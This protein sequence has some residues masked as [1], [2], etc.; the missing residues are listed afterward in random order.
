VTKIANIHLLVLLWS[1]VLPVQAASDLTELFEMTLLE[2]SNVSVTAEKR[3]S[4]L[5][6]VPISITIFSSEQLYDSN[7]RDIQE[8]SPYTPNMVFNRIGGQAQIYIRGVGSD[9]LGVGSD[10]ST[11]VHLDGIYLGRPEMALA[12]FLDV[13][14]I[15][16]LHGPQGTLYGRNSIGGNINIISKG[17]TAHWEGYAT[18]L[19][20][21]FDR[22]EFTAAVGGPLSDSIGIRLSIRKEDD[23]G[24]TDDLD[25]LGGDEIDDTDALNARVILD[26]DLRD[27]I[28]FR[29]IGDWND[30]SD[31]G[32]SIRPIDNLGTAQASGAVA[33]NDFHDTRNNLST[34]NDNETGGI[35]GKLNIDFGDYQFNSI[36]GFRVLDTAS[37]FNTDGTEIDVTETQ[38]IRDQEQFSQEL[39]LLYDGGKRWN[40]ITGLYY[41]YENSSIELGL[42]RA[43]LGTSTVINSSNET[44]AWAAFI[45]ATFKITERWKLEAGLRYSSES[46]SDT[47]V[48]AT[49]ADTLG[50][51]SPLATTI[52][53]ATAGKHTYE[54]PTPEFGAS[55]QIDGNQSIY[56]SASRGFKSGGTNSFSTTAAFD[57]EFIWSYETGYKS[58]HMGN[59][60][61]L[62]AAMF[63]SDY[64]DLQVLSF[65]G[66]LTSISNAA[67]ATIWGGE[68][69]SFFQQTRNLQ[70]SLAFSYL[71]AK[72]D[73]FITSRGGAAV[74]VSGNTVQSAPEF[75]VSAATQYG[76]MLRD[77]GQLSLRA[78]LNYQS[79][80]FFDQFN[81]DVVKEDGY[82]LVNLMT[83]F[84]SKHYPIELALFMKN[85]FDHEYNQNVVRFT[86]TSTNA[87]GNALGSA[88][89]GRSINFQFVYRF[90]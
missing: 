4:T 57:P 40:W 55:Y 35:T 2:L 73:E 62:N 82:A 59:R 54:A 79:E 30:F 69:E 76:Y 12:H 6:E 74:D 39:Q 26:M 81:D 13:E 83:T 78:E 61:R 86:T 63:Y 43:P 16:I 42:P 14:R 80:V 23:S 50:L 11:T 67:A 20:G 41:F 70:W 44:N 10:A 71:N 29:L 31:H 28:D 75:T 68:L 15:E 90:E 60:L 27:R 85:V 87:A 1:I 48:F 84:E 18:A 32:R 46:K 21:S 72:Y 49:V 56:V 25:L 19:A 36:T 89:P 17:P 88:A 3:E 53:A 66:G 45:N 47:R 34:F 33:T 37:S 9:T 64:S 5:Q 8:L 22:T 24:F 38:F 52:I 58:M 7:I 65:E 51:N 77:S